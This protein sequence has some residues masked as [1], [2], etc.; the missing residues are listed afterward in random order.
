MDIHQL[1]GEHHVLKLQRKFRC[2][3]CSRKDYIEVEFKMLTGGEMKDIV[4]RELVEIRMVKRAIW[5]DKKL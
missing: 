4:L 3:K 2:E 5:R 1:I